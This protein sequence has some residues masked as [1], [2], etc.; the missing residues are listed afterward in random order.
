MDIKTEEKIMSLYREGLDLS[1]ISK[2]A[3][4][5]YSAVYKLTRL[6]DRINPETGKN[7][8][9]ETEYRSYLTRRKI[10]PETGKNFES[11]NEYQ[12]YCA[13]KR[14]FNSKTHY[15]QVLT[16]SKGFKGTHDYDEFL[17][18]KR[19]YKHSYE[20]QKSRAKRKGFASINEYQDY[21]NRQ[22]QTNEENIKLSRFLKKRL[23]ELKITQK[24]LA[25]KIGVSNEAVS[26]YTQ[27]KYIPNQ[28]VLE[29]IFTELRT[30][31]KTLDD[32]LETS[33]N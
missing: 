20:Y 24:H 17:L 30:N 18:K 5:G 26:K 19:G 2:E 3:G 25:K 23:K 29:R 10:N 33:D 8:E 9:T 22:K 11:L 28:L 15:K 7:F 31:Y 27:G 12:D 14:G 32:L 16:A 1:E 4:V 13:R 21:L 6:K